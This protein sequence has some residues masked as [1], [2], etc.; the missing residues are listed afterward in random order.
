V[1]AL[2]M[3]AAA[4]HIYVARVDDSL[5]RW[6]VGDADEAPQRLDAVAGAGQIAALGF[7][8]GDTSL[9]VGDQRGGQSVWFPVREDGEG[10]RYLRRIRELPDAGAAVKSWQRFGRDRT[11]AALTV[12]GRVVFDHA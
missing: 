6:A 12:D 8:L 7:V 10:E 1:R 5:E 4:K 11:V 9:L 2:A 3:D